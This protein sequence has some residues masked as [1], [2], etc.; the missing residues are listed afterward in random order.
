MG[1]RD[2]LL[3]GPLGFGTAPLGNMYRNISDEEAT[4]T[5]DAAWAAGIRLFD[6]A[7]FY[8]AGLAE[9]RL[10]KALA[11]YPRDEYVLATKVGRLVLP[12]LVDTSTRTFGDKG[13][14][15][16][17]GNANAI[18]YDYT[19][20]GTTRSI[21][22]SLDRLGVDRLDYVFIHDLAQDFHGDDWTSKFVEAQ[23][24]AFQVLDKLRDDGVITAWGQGTNKVEPIEIG[25]ELSEPSAN[26]MLLAGRYTILDHESALQRLMPLAIREDVDVIVGGPYNSGALVGGAHFEYG[27]IPPE[28]A[29]RVKTIATLCEKHDV[30]I[31]AAALHFSLAHPAVA[32]VIPGSSRP[33]RIVE[34]VAAIR[35][36]VPEDFW[37]DLRDSGVVSTAA[38]LPVDD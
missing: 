11:K 35:F 4:A 37:R 10:G 30:P 27:P 16:K 29:D 20:E 26:G 13:N 23:H 34:D 15:F 6:A 1:I 38:P 25:L 31:K 2:T 33:G 3:A 24:G 28:I 32:A 17:D 18:R 9:V 21:A 36:A 8:G 22:E 12:E 19:A 5:V 7:P 14:I